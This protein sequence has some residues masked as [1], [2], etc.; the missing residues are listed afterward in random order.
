[1][2]KLLRQLA[3]NIIQELATKNMSRKELS[4]SETMDEITMILQR[5]CPIQPG[6]RGQMLQVYDAVVTFFHPWCDTTTQYFREEVW[7]RYFGEPIPPVIV[8]KGM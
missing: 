6:T 3:A 4:V 7:N 1:M 8:N 5:D 2:N